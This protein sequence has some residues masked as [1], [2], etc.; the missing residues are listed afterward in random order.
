MIIPLG[1]EIEARRRPVVT[2]IIVLLN[3]IAMVAALLAIRAQWFDATQLLEFAA[4]RRHG[5]EWW[6]PFTYQFM[7]DLNGVWHLLFNMLFLWVFGT[8]VEGRL[9]RVGFLA[10]YLIGGAVA[11]LVHIALSDHP[12][13]G[14]SGA[15]A[16]CSGAFLALF[17]RA[18]IRLVV[19]FFMIGVWIVPAAWF[20]G[21]YFVADLLA[22]T[23]SLLGHGTSNV[24]YL[25]H[26]AGYL[27]GF[28]V[29]FLLLATRI[30]PRGE[31]DLFRL[32][33][34]WRRR[35]AMREASRTA[36]HLSRSPWSAPPKAPPSKVAAPAA[37]VGPPPRRAPSTRSAAPAAP[38][39]GV[40][41]P[42]EATAALRREISSLV[43]RH[44]IPAATQRYLDLVRA[45]PT[46]VLPELQQLDVASQLL[47]D[48]RVDDAARA[49]EAF[50]SAHERSHKADDV[51]LLLASVYTRRLP[52]AS[53]AK[54]LLEAIRGRLRDARHVA[55]ADELWRELAT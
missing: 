10:F 51:R 6:Q 49:Y 40:A 21:F 41:N 12:V 52:N 32:F 44:E 48:G 23:T 18:R 1:T 33:T 17:P 30:L 9:G 24:A 15:V 20:I 4:L 31:F 13:I 55:L 45:H 3:G 7:H 53:K 38:G 50:L 46:T 42:D 35:V 22:Q 5:F 39:G 28:G 25:A 14:A 54:P 34:L 43:E 37:P 36:A 19:V 11:G 2:P 29:A 47:A 26:L 16:A 8:A 27:Y